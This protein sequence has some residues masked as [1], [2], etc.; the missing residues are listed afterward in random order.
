MFAKLFEH[1]DG[2]DCN[3]DALAGTCDKNGFEWRSF[4]MKIF[5][6]DI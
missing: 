5:I 3:F 2:I 6:L 4:W 1:G